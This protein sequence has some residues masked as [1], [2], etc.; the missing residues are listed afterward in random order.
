M[1][2]KLHLSIIFIPNFI[3][4]FLW[5]RTLKFPPNIGPQY[6]FTTFLY[7]NFNCLCTN[8]LKKNVFCHCWRTAFP[9]Y[10]AAPTI[11]NSGFSVFRQIFSGGFYPMGQEVI[12]IFPGSHPKTVDDLLHMLTFWMHFK[13][14]LSR[15]QLNFFFLP[16]TTDGK[17]KHSKTFIYLFSM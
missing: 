2:Y 1:P 8:T 4:S 14:V 12:Y 15:P 5:M 9:Q 10:D 7:E 16:N 6:N 13:I 17:C 11:F 3:K